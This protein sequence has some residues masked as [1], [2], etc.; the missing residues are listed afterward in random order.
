VRGE[1]RGE[2]SITIKGKLNKLGQNKSASSFTTN[3]TR[4][5]LGFYPRVPV[6][7]AIT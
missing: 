3:F 2:M 5:L 6:Q 1:G 4:N 7:E